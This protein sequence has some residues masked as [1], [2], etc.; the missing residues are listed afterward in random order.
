V[1]FGL[2]ADPDV[3]KDGH[4]FFLFQIGRAKGMRQKL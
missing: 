1:G 4:I 3:G 2:F